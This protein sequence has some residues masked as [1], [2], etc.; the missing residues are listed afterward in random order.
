[1]AHQ[2][3]QKRTV[4]I[5][6]DHTGITAEALSRSL[7]AQFEGIEI[8]KRMCPFITTKEDAE[9]LLL[10]IKAVALTSEERPLIFSTIADPKI[11]AIIQQADAL[12]IDIFRGFLQN[13]A[14]EL[15]QE[16]QRRIGHYHGLSGIEDIQR[17]QA[18]MDSLEFALATDDGLGERRYA[19]AGVILMGVSRTGKT[20][21]CLYLALQNG[22]R[23]ANYPLTDEDF[24]KTGL[25]KQLEAHKH[26]LFGLTIEPQR[27]HEIRKVRRPDSEY[28][29][30]KQCNY[31]VRWAENLYKQMGIPIIN[32]TASS[33]EEISSSLMV[34]LKQ[35]AKG[36]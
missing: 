25:P 11:C 28:A 9:A 4:F 22:I 2:L 18:R 3:T 15:K 34:K 7:L 33:V 21:T 13:L 1:M 20:P 36:N 27:L 10:E 6:S 29:S 5:V 31:E 30:Q 26:L 32:T 19:E 12:E 8:D 23:A 14:T 17:Y 16:P 24:S 35:M